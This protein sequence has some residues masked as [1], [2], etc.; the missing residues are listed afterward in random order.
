MKPVKDTYIFKYPGSGY[1]ALPTNTWTDH[2]RIFTLVEIMRQHDENEFCEVLNRLRKARCTQ[3]NH[4]LFQSCI[5][6]KNSTKYNP[7]VR[8][9][10]PFKN[11]T[12]KHIEEFLI[13]PKSIKRLLNLDF[14]IGTHSHEELTI[15]LMKIKL[16]QNMN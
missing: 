2:F 14:L 3:A 5:V 15:C 1:S 9:I 4:N 8:H 6:D 12:D 16:R 10:Y 7:Y 13:K 11:A